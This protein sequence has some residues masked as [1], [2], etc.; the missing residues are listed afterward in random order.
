MERLSTLGC[1]YT[2][3]T[4]RWKQRKDREYTGPDKH[5][6]QDRDEKNK[7]GQQRQEEQNK[8]D[9]ERRKQYEEKEMGEFRQMVQQQQQQQLSNKE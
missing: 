4:I 3:S 6:Q 8:R 1:T 9:E 7:L 2:P 5:I